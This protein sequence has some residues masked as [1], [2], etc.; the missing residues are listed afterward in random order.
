MKSNNDHLVSGSNDHL[1]SVIVPVYNGAGFITDTLLSV[2]DQTHDHLECIIVDDGSVDDTAIIVRQWIKTDNRFS[3]IYQDNKGLS[4]ARNTGLAHAKGSFIQFLDADDILLPSKIEK[5]LE[6]IKNNTPDSRDMI[7]SYTDYSTGRSSDIFEPAGYYRAAQFRSTDYLAEFIDR[8][9]SDLTIPPHCFL[10]TAN[11]FFERN[12]RFDTGLPNHEDFD[13]WLNILRLQPRIKYL[14]QKLCIYRVTEGSMS[15]N[16]RLMGEGF[17]QVLEKQIRTPDQPK[18]IKRQL[19]SKRRAVLK[20]YYR[21]DRM[22]LN[23]KAHLIF[24]IFTYYR[25]RAL[26]KAGITPKPIR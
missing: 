2:K 5:Q 3:Y 6:D 21:F 1:V 12:I 14:D 24:F 4:A 15:K 11:L 22:S 19:I 23:D 17:L 25:K 18:T 16:M 8:W 10:F 13:C 9:E 7:V 20:R 26:H